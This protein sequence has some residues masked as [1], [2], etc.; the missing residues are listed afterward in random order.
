M[1]GWWWLIVAFLV[2]ISTACLIVGLSVRK[3]YAAARTHDRNR[4]RWPD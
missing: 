2:G 3:G 4:G 1:V